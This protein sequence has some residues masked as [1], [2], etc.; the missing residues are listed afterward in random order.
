MREASTYAPSHEDK[1]A[2][3]YFPKK[4]FKIF[5]E[6]NAQDEEK[7]RSILRC[8]KRETN[9]KYDKSKC[10][11]ETSRLRVLGKIRGDGNEDVLSNAY[12]LER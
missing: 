6:G 12:K 8:G 5:K 7:D 4:R 1:Q 9:N 2:I 3:F 10:L 11:P